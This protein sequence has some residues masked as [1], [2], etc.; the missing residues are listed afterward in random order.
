M[1]PNYFF[2]ANSQYKKAFK[3]NQPKSLQHRRPSEKHLTNEAINKIGLL[4]ATLKHVRISMCCVINF[5]TSIDN[6][7]KIH[8]ACM[9]FLLYSIDKHFSLIN[10]RWMLF[11]S[12]IGHVYILSTD[13]RWSVKVRHLD[14]I[15]RLDLVSIRRRPW[16]M[17][18]CESRSMSTGFLGKGLTVCWENVKIGR[19]F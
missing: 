11:L 12:V 19:F 14:M 6:H 17:K 13:L 4:A 5:L 3:Q 10:R 16:N 7:K 15:D 2:K 8:S 1:L 18:F 9:L